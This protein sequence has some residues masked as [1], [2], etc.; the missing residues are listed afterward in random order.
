ME[1]LAQPL[2]TTLKMSSSRT[3]PDL[4]MELCFLFLAVW[5]VAFG[6]LTLRSEDGLTAVEGKGLSVFQQR[7][8]CQPSSAGRAGLDEV[9][10]GLVTN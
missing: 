8:L 6:S 4:A 5:I 7:S 2:S 1:L 9:Q 10:K 3:G